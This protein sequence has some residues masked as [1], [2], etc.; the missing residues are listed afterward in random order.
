[1]TLGFRPSLRLRLVLAGAV[2]V[3]L[4]L[5]VSAIGL[6]ALFGAHVE[7]RALV[8]M[9]AALDQV[10]AGLDL[11]AT[12]HID[13]AAA[14]VDARFDQ[15]YS[16][17]YWQ[18]AL[19]D[20]VLRSRSLWDQTL[21]LADPPPADGQV[22]PLRLTG[23][24]DQRLLAAARSVTLP[25]RLGGGTAVALVA[26]DSAAL[27]RARRDFVA[28][29]APYMGLLAAVLIAAG[30]V[31]IT[32]GLR[33]LVRLRARAA[34]LRRDPAARMGSDWPAEV[35][36]LARELDAMLDARATDLDRARHRASDLAHGLKTPLQALM[37]EAARLRDKGAAA[38]AD[39][40]EDVVSAMRRTVD[41]E[42]ARAR[43]LADPAPS[44]SDLAH[45]VRRVLA[46]V[47]K[48]PDGR[49]VDWGLDLDAD[50]AVA[51]DAGDLSEALGA[52]IENAA[53]HARSRVQI[54]GAAA[55]D[56]ITLTIQDDG[57]GIPAPQ[58]EAMLAR[59]GRLDERGS[60]MGLGIARDIVTDAGGT[61]DLAA[62][63][64]TGGLCVRLAFPA[65][66]PGG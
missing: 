2:A 56:Q 14:P 29:L 39:S 3:V 61:L 35:T 62:C 9:S 38:E 42:L 23:P 44:H 31:Q 34:Q 30:Y 27:T 55:G 17:Q 28:D 40:I 15:P 4:A 64:T 6:S 57:P 33:P 25:A 32:V 16:G 50:L 54:T 36:A 41:G 11:S 66:R 8:E 5:G 7:R 10:L 65:R 37:G 46:V 24:L 12:G 19:Q 51:L 47:R 21:D 59:F 20:R 43:R 1:M 60:G 13:M 49:R 45:A 53:R 18:I 48:T 52:V 63:E 26:L 22:W 58:R